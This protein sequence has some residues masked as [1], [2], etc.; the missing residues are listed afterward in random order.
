M[1]EKISNGTNKK[2]EADDKTDI[3]GLIEKKLV[4]LTILFKKQY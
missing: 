4:S 1:N 2:K 3:I